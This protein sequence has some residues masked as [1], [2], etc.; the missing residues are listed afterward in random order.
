MTRVAVVVT[1]FMAGAGGVALRG[2][3]ALPGDDWEITFITGGGDRTIAEARAA[4]FEVVLHDHLRADLSARHDGRALLELGAFL[5]RHRFDVVHTHSSKA[6]A[7]GRVAARWAGVDRVVHTFHGFPFHQ[8]QSPLR[9]GAYI[10]AERRL[11]AITDSF[12]AVGPAVAAEAVRRRIVRPQHVR[13]IGVAV[14]P[15]PTGAS[16]G[17]AEARRRLGVPPGTSAVGTVGR[18]DFQKAPEHFLAALARLDR[19]DVYGVWIGDGPLRSKCQ[20]LVGRYGLTG[21]VLFLGQR[22]DVPALLPGLDLFVMASRYEGLP[23]AIVEA[24]VAGLPVVATA[25]NSVPDVVIPG[26]TGLLVPPGRPA[27][28]AGAIAYMLDHPVAADRMAYTGRAALGESLTP[29]ALGRILADTY[30]D[31]PVAPYERSLTLVAA[32]GGR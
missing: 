7:L 20:A 29:A 10:S 4:G 31:E 27:D 30:R 28:L 22:D 15:H 18:L 21:R 24:M 1:R 14:D 32:G 23:C 16:A 3:L 26:E 19:P 11:A 17:R 2:A 12:L 6:G 25:V 13:T 5:R 9:R 8:F